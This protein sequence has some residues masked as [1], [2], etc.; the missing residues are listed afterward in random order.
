[1]RQNYLETL[2]YKP[3]ECSTPPDYPMRLSVEELGI[4]NFNKFSKPLFYG[5]SFG[6]IE[7]KKEGSSCLYVYYTH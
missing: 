4:W 3:P 5:V 2:K 1:M 6:T 7:E